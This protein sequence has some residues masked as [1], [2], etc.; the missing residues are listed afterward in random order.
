MTGAA[1]AVGE[2][3]SRS[4]LTRRL[5]G[6]TCERLG[7]RP[8]D[9]RYV[10]KQAYRRCRR[11]PLGGQRGRDGA[12][13]RVSQAAANCGVPYVRQIVTFSDAA[14]TSLPIRLHGSGWPAASARADCCLRREEQSRPALLVVVLRGSSI[15]ASAGARLVREQQSRAFSPSRPG[16]GRR[17]CLVHGN[18]DSFGSAADAPESAPAG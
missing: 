10:G 4:L 16:E 13:S 1:A 11:P 3:A 5:P 8:L 12:R 9:A 15:T 6:T 17:N 2:Q 7:R 14:R 18:S